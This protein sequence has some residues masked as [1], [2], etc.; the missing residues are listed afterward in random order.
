MK[1]KNLKGYRRHTLLAANFFNV[2]GWA[3]L[4]PLYALYV[5][6]LGGNAQSAA[7]AWGLYTLLGGVSIIVLGW[8]ENRISKKERILA[9]GAT[10]QLLGVGVLFAATDMTTMVAGY[11]IYAVGTGFVVPV[12][13]HAYASVQIRG[14][15]TAEWGFLNGG[16]MLLFAAAAILSSYLFGIY[17]FK[18]LLVLMVIA[19]VIG[20]TFAFRLLR[21]AKL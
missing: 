2:F 15:S 18:G 16:N 5:T 20:A 11:G 8:W 14:K 13:N 3:L 17:G 4:S 21:V 10:L 7:L 9:L 1:I 12:W 19:H 6:E